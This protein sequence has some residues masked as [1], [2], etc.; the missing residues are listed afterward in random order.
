MTAIA[1]VQPAA[2]SVVRTAGQNARSSSTERRIAGWSAVAFATLVLISN[3]IVGATPAFDAPTD[4]VARFIADHRTAHALS[5]AV[6]ALGAPFLVGFACAFYGR[7][8]A[9]CRD[10]DLVWARIGAAGVLLIVPMFAAVVVPRIVLVVG[11][12]EVIADPALVALVWRFE[13]AAFFLNMLAVG[14]ALTG[15]GVAAGRSGLVPRWFGKWAPIAGAM[16]LASA[17]ST[18]ASMEGAAVGM[19]GFGAFLS[20]M[21][22]LYL[23]GIRQLRTAD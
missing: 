2:R 23:A 10:A 13:I 1:D 20:W 3:A 8:R 16:A 7:L 18:I 5:V 19:I 17:V 22:F 15:L 12:D 4:E 9:A 14:I 21:L 6:F 11:Y